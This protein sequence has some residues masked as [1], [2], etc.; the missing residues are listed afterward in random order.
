[1]AT[2]K[3]L[4]PTN[5]TISIPAMTDTP[6]AAVFS[7][8]ID[9]EADAINTLSSQISYKTISD[10]ND[11]IPTGSSTKHIYGNCTVG[12]ASNAPISGDN[13][14]YRAEAIGTTSYFTQEALVE[15]ATTAG[16]RGRKFIRQCLNSEFTPWVEIIERSLTQ[17]IAASASKTFTI[18]T[19]GMCLVKIGGYRDASCGVAYLCR[20]GTN[21]LVTK[22][23]GTAPSNITISMSND[24]NGTVTIA[25]G[26]TISAINVWIEKLGGGTIAW[27]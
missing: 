18:N 21:T 26:D 24:G 14:T 6:D 25:N 1:M 17:T 23:L 19:Y 15:Y 4:S 12:S 27:N 16:N 3:T 10:F 8:C 7:N 9:K 20:S 13:I 11:F 2:S 22:W 5:V